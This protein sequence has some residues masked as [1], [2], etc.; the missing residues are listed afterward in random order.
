MRPP[1]EPID[2]N[3][4]HSQTPAGESGLNLDQLVEE[5]FDYLCR[6]ANRHFRSPDKVEELVQETF[7]AATEARSR[8]RNQSSPRTWLVGIL[9]HK[10]IDAIRM[11]K[12]DDEKIVRA[13]DP[14]LTG[15]LFHKQGHWR[16]ENGPCSW[17]LAGS[18]ALSGSGSVP[19]DAVIRQRQFL[20]VIDK[21]LSKLPER[22]RHIFLLREIEEQDRGEISEAL[23]LTST[24]V[25]VI[26][27]RARL[28][29]QECVQINW[30]QEKMPTGEA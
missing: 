24:N 6:Y 30:L 3:N 17:E 18:W 27:H 5:H 10:I 8:F 1:P 19:A 26:L 9:R 28:A 13:D 29:L 14:E 2:Q 22:V 16:E 21:C 15:R 7:L 12:R 25:G 23:N 4:P 11:K 20:T